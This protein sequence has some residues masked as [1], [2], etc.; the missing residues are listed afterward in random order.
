VRY[1]DDLQRDPLLS[2]EMA[3]RTDT[4]QLNHVAKVRLIKPLHDG[5]NAIL[6][7]FQMSTSRILFATLLIASR[8]LPLSMATN[9]FDLTAKSRSNDT[10]FFATT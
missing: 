6:Y 7:N 5:V 8:Q 1:A 3:S 9:G 2:A 10:E 4:Y